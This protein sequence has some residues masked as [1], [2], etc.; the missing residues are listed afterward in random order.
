MTKRIG[1]SAAQTEG[2]PLVRIRSLLPGLARAEQRV[3]NVVLEDPAAVTHR[4]ITEV[5]EAA[6]TSETTVTR[7]CKAIGIRGYPELRLALAA[8]TARNAVRDEQKLGGEIG[9]GDDLHDVIGKV[10]YADARAVEETAEQLDPIALRKVVDRVSAARRVDVYGVGA[11][12]FVAMDLQ[13]KLH[14]IGRVSFAWNDKH[15][16]LTSAAVLS[17]DDVAVG[18]SHTG[19]TADVIEALRVARAR[20]ATTVAITNFPRAPI[21]EVAD[22]VLTTAA[23]ETTFRS[24]AMASRIAQLTLIDCLFI[25]VAQQHYETAQEALE[26]TYAAVVGQRLGSRPDGRRKARDGI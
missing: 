11:S 20:G 16:A 1:Q 8:D 21:T 12:A 26:V 23:R 25:G 10:A 14:R 7:F 18:I 9:P 13:Q 17:E 15:I 2:S 22:H 24:G 6:G 19:S 4:S 3:A 5:A